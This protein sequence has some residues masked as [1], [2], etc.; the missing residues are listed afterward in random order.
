MPRYVVPNAEI[1]DMIYEYFDAIEVSH[2]K[3]VMQS[4]YAK[5]EN[6]S[7]S[8]IEYPLTIKVS[9]AA[10]EVLEYIIYQLE[11]ELEESEDHLGVEV[12]S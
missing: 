12:L 11:D 6:A 9:D 7:K 10:A 4:L 8:E 2:P 5:F 3:P 1:F